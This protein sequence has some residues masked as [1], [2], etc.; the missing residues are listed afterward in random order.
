MISWILA[1]SPSFTAPAVAAV[2]ASCTN[3]PSTSTLTCNP[4]TG[5][6]G[7]ELLVPIFENDD[8]GQSV[9][10]AAKPAGWNLAAY[11][12]DAPLG[13][14]GVTTPDT[15]M[16][17]LGYLQQMVITKTAISPSGTTPYTIRG[18]FQ[19]PQMFNGG[20]GIIG[21]DANQNGTNDTLDRT[22]RLNTSGQII[23]SHGAT[24]TLLG[25]ATT[26]TSPH[27]YNDGL[28]HCATGTFDGT[29]M[30]LYMS[31]G[32][33]TLVA[34]PT[35][36]STANVTLPTIGHWNI[37]YTKQPGTY[38]GGPFIE[39]QIAVW[40]GTALSLAN[41]QSLDGHMTDGTYDTAMAA[42]SPSYW[43]K[44]NET[45]LGLAAD[46]AGS[47]TGEYYQFNGALN[48]LS[49]GGMGDMSPWFGGS[50]LGLGFPTFT[51]GG[52]GAFMAAS[53][54]TTPA[55]SYTISAFIKVPSPWSGGGSIAGYT[56]IT[57]NNQAYA[58][59]QGVLYVDTNNKL[60]FGFWCGTQGPVTT[61][62]SVTVNDDTVHLVQGIWT[63]SLLQLYIDNAQSGSSTAC[64]GGAGTSGPW[65]P[66]VGS[67]AIGTVYYPNSP[68]NGG[69]SGPPAGG[70]LP[71]SV[72]RVAYFVNSTLSSGNISSLNAHKNDG[73][74][75]TVMAGF[76][77]THYYKLN[78][79]HGAMAVDSGSS[80]N[81]GTYS[82]FLRLAWTLWTKTRAASESAVTFPLGDNALAVGQMV[83]VTNV[84]PTVDGVGFYP[85]SGL[86]TNVFNTGQSIAPSN[87][88]QLSLLG[89]TGTVPYLGS[90]PASTT[91][92][93][94]GNYGAFG[95]TGPTVPDN[96]IAL[97]G[98]S[99]YIYSS[100]SQV[101]PELSSFSNVL[102]FKVPN[103][104]S[105]GGALIGLYDHPT[106][107]Q[108]SSSAIPTMHMDNSGHIVCTYWA[109][110][111]T[112]VS[113]TSTYNDGN[114]HLAFCTAG[115]G[116]LEVYVDSNTAQAS[117]S[118]SGSTGF[119]AYWIIGDGKSG[120]FAPA[121]PSSTFIK[122]T[123]LGEAAIFMGT[124][125]TPTQIQ[126]LIT[127]QNDG[128]FDSTMAGLSPT[129][130]WKLNDSTSTIADSAGSNTGT[131]SG[132]A[133]LMAQIVMA[134]FQSSMVDDGGYAY[135]SGG[136]NLG[137]DILLQ[138]GVPPLPPSGGSLFFREED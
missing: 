61:V 23:Y 28:R 69:A 1:A 68:G 129:Y 135:N 57:T 56:D 93:A 91:L 124:V 78:E 94:A 36:P 108:G 80:V 112:Q 8:P 123:S 58:R 59:P 32:G 83:D 60:N 126:S 71:L 18:C 88:L 13:L 24:G 111:A 131:F 16:V 12:N 137:V 89:S 66:T 26:I 27:K 15:S 70:G 65:P 43:W 35:T 115:G 101:S 79:K 77:P 99:Q 5:T 84:T 52:T 21:D 62:S 98:S 14:V 105:S 85:M 119:T 6:A 117:S 10:N 74:F 2:G 48:Q 76:S 109:G 63:G 114:F 41:V 113:S 116:T 39:G 54:E 20:G 120:S 3:T 92:A 51:A 53:N 130:W 132:T 102:G 34:G 64:S 67:F 42:L 81:N 125:L 4:P 110:S 100:V 104:Y 90:Y 11:Q 87:D 95:V 49:M 25:G 33:G 75:D 50:M 96:G 29:Q 73:T 37:D 103:G 138:E 40:N 45:A 7:D 121:T 31:D 82:N 107:I 133:Q 47:N 19:I 17:G 72:G 122:A 128:A 46:S 44:L 86:D 134:P 97:D 55:T 38:Y 106:N 9:L 22:L 30:R 136:Y 118:I 127:H